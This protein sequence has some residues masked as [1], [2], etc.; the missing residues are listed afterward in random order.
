MGHTCLDRARRMHGDQS[1]MRN[2]PW[3][4]LAAFLS[5]AAQAQQ[6]LPPSVKAAIEQSRKDC[7]RQKLTMDRGFIKRRDVNG[8]GVQDFI[9]NYEHA[10][11]GDF[12]SFFCG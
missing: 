7:G 1:P 12:A 2:L 5:P 8:D 9:L 11:C 3:V 4:V 6:G 10:A